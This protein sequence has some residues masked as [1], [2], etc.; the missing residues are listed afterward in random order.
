MHGMAENNPYLTESKA[1]EKDMADHAVSAVQ[2]ISAVTR[3]LEAGVSVAKIGTTVG[4]GA[5]PFIGGAIGNANIFKVVGGSAAEGAKNILNVGAIGTF[6]G[7]AVAVARGA[8]A[9]GEFSKGNKAK[10]T[11]KI[12]RGAVEAAGVV[13]NLTGIYSIIEVA[14]AFTG[15][16]I[17]Q[18]IADFAEDNT[19][20][21][22]GGDKENIAQTNGNNMGTVAVAAGGLAAAGLVANQ[23]MTKEGKAVTVGGLPPKAGGVALQTKPAVNV[24][25]VL[26]TNYQPVQAIDRSQASNNIVP[27]N[28]TEQAQ[29]I[30]ANNV[31]N[32][33]RAQPAAGMSATH[34]Q[35]KVKAERQQGQNIAV[36]PSASTDT[37]AFANMSKVDVEAAR[38]QLS[39]QQNQ[40]LTPA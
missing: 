9:I 2:G 11:G 5:V 29:P 1:K 40:I 31:V 23:M 6:M 33:T 16:S 24:P 35:D 10:G 39:A 20:N 13:L 25:S 34:W 19:V 3:T 38:R 18:R 7:G 15:R 12:V 4:A 8:Q 22:L 17:T 21:I 37:T 26:P 36:Q 28:R 14:S 27:F 30:A 32:F